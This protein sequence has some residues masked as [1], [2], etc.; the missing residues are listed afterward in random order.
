[1][2]ALAIWETGHAA[3][4]YSDYHRVLRICDWEQQF[5][6]SGLPKNPHRANVDRYEL[7]DGLQFTGGILPNH[8]LGPRNA[9]DQR[10]HNDRQR[11]PE[12]V[13][14]AQLH[15]S[16]DQLSDELRIDIPLAVTPIS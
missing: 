1:M 7:H 10:R 5:R 12:Y 11:Q 15:D 4:G 14:S 6:C 9:A 3:G 13:V 2:M 8:L 16:A